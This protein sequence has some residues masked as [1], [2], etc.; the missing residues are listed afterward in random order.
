MN[1]GFMNCLIIS[2]LHEL[3]SHLVAH[4]IG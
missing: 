3:L 2:T 1:L 4:H